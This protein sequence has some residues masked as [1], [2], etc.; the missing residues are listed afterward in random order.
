MARFEFRLETLLKLRRS[1]QHDRRRRLAEAE[2]AIRRLG[3]Q[4]DE[5]RNQH[6][7]LQQT[8]RQLAAPGPLNVD[9]LVQAQRYESVLQAQCRA[10]EEQVALIQTECERRRQALVAASREVRTLENYRD[11]LR[12][13]HR[14]EQLRKEQQQHDETAGQREAVRRQREKRCSA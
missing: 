5:L 2:E 6:I 9:L 13:K 4:H 3:M 10:I 7:A 14:H 1:Q 11:R 12:D 8:A